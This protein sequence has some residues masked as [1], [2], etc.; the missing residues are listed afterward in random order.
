MALTNR[1]KILLSVLQSY[2]CLRTSE[3]AM[4]VFSGIRTTTVLRR[5][6]RL[7]ERSYIQKICGLE[8]TERL[9]ALTEKTMQSFLEGA[10]KI[11]FPKA[12]LEHDSRLSSLRLRLEELKVAESWVP[13]HEIR[14][15]VAT[16]YGVKEGA[17]KVI[18]DGLMGTEV[19]GVKVSIAV[20]LELTNKNQLRYRDILRDYS[21]KK[22]VWAVWYVT[23][24]QSTDRQILK[25]KRSLYL[26]DDRPRILFSNVDD[27][28][29]NG[30]SA[31]IYNGKTESSIRDLFTPKSSKASA[32]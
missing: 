20:E 32:H 16:R 4:K 7:E 8:S 21:A 13:E 26:I 22:N 19:D 23:Q 12:I 18:P 25:A 24:S 6:R 2:G 9:W 29:A 17:R 14:R 10:A 5:L 15:Q 30:L 11:H 28:T 31:R 27:V 1:D 3:I